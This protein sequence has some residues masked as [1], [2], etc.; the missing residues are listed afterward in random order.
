MARS[1]H[2]SARPSGSVIM[3][4]WH[5]KETLEEALWFFVNC[6]SPDAAYADSCHAGIA[7]TIG[8]SHW[9]KQVAGYLSNLSTLD[10][11]VGV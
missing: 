5:D 7:I 4:T 1:A 9:A 10:A 6:S 2:Q 11:A 3:T 8:N